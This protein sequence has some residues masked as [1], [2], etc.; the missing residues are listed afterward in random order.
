MALFVYITEECKK[1]AAKHGRWNDV[2][3]LKDKIISDQRTN[4]LDRYPPPYLK[5]RF[6]RQERLIAAER[7]VADHTVVCFYRLLIRGNDTY[8][9]FKNNPVVF[10]DT[11]F[12][13]L[14]QEVKLEEWLET[15]LNQLDSG[16]K[17]PA[18]EIEQTY[19]WNVMTEGSAFGGDFHIY[20]SEDWVKAINT[21]RLRS[22]LFPIANK[23]MDTV[24]PDVKEEFQWLDISEAGNLKVLFRNFK[25]C[26]KVFLAGIC[27]NQDE[28]EQERL[29]QRYGSILKEAQVDGN[30]IIRFSNRSY[31]ALILADTDN[32]EAIEKNADSNLALS[33]EE[34]SLLAS[35]HSLD[36][37]ERQTGF[38]LF[39]NGRAGSGK[40]TIL[41]YLFTHYVIN[42]L[43]HIG[44]TSPPLYLT[45]SEDL[46]RR[47]KE[48][49]E[50]LVTS[51]Y[52]HTM[53]DLPRERLPEVLDSCFQEFKSFLINLIPDEERNILFSAEKYVNYPRF[54]REWEQKFSKDPKAAKAYGPDISW[55][56]IRTY[57][58]G[59]SPDDYMDPDEY[60]ELPREEYSVS[61]STFKKVYT[62]VWEGWYQHKCRPD[63]EE[64]IYWDDQDLV[65]YVLDNDLIL[66]IYPAVFCDEAQDFTKI[67]LEAILRLSLF[68][69]RK[70]D[71]QEL[72]RIPFAFAGDPLQTL[73][74]TGFRW[75]AIKSVFVQKFIHSLDPQQIFGQRELNYRELSYNYRS[76]NKVVKLNNSIQ[77]FRA[78]LFDIKNLQPQSTWQ[79]EENSPTPVFFNKSIPEVKERLKEQ[80]DLTIIVPCGEGGEKGFVKNDPYL[81]QV[82]E[83]DEEGVPQNV[84]SP[85]RSKGLEFK[86]VA[87][88]GFGEYMPEGFIKLIEAI[89][90]D[91]V[92]EVGD[93]LL[94]YGYFVNQLYVAASRPQKRL[95]VVDT[96]EGIR[97][98]WKFAVD[99]D[100]QQAI[101][102]KIRNGEEIWKDKLG[103][104]H[105]G[106]S[107]SWSQDREDPIKRAKQLEEEGKYSRDQFLLRQAAM[108]YKNHNEI[109]KS[110]LCRALAFEFNQQYK[111]AGN[112]Y[113]DGESVENALQ[114]F[115][116]GAEYAEIEAIAYKEAISNTLEARISVYLSESTKSLGECRRVLDELLNRIER[117]SSLAIRIG[118]MESWRRAIRKIL[119]SLL[120]S[121]L[122]ESENMKTIINQ[123]KALEENNIPLDQERMG[124]LYLKAGDFQQGLSILDQSG[125]MTSHEYKAAKI[126]LLIDRYRN[127][128]EHSFEKEENQ[129][130][131][132][133]FLEKDEF[134]D[135]ITVFR[136]INSYN[137]VARVINK[138]VQTKKNSPALLSSFANTFLQLLLAN[139]EWKNAVTFIKTQKHLSLDSKAS[140]KLRRLDITT[141]LTWTIELLKTASISPLLP[142]APTT[143]KSALSD[144]LRELFFKEDIKSEA[145]FALLPSIVVGAAFE[146][147][148]RDI[149]TLEF[150]KRAQR[151]N[152]LGKA[153]KVRLKE[154]WIKSK[155]KQAIRERDA[156]KLRQ[157]EKHFSDAEREAEKRGLVVSDLSEFPNAN[158]LQTIMKTA[159]DA[160][161]SPLIANLPESEVTGASLQKNN[162]I[163]PR[164]VRSG[165]LPDRITLNICGFEIKVSRKLKR[166]NIEKEA[167]METLS[168][169][170]NN[171]VQIIHADV[172]YEDSQKQV[173]I[174]G[175][176]L[177]LEKI[178]EESLKLELEA[179]GLAFSIQ[180]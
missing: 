178:I 97:G 103:A 165:N 75:E 9:S 3:K 115:W 164:E 148:G 100:F 98:L 109:R 29:L 108:I 24:A 7:S 40:S 49:V 55:H 171:G 179:D 136:K 155:H 86:R 80:V 88:Y 87:L 130:I 68:S 107:E 139:G 53:R 133:F 177:K 69:D 83:V 143:Q 10:G 52:Q 48:V 17:E 11:H 160:P 6:A 39:I 59:I 144:Y 30:D 18:D 79:Y 99:P 118:A 1:D 33:P 175:W 37:A 122:S 158:E 81:R 124:R 137:G 152:S 157:A 121:D 169:V 176:H 163:H 42:Y 174:K 78:A 132:Q 101:L 46:V 43:E 15:Q 16:V 35:A 110:H 8:N 61:R 116:K 64:R 82:I 90:T 162:G 51:N 25:S 23:L 72:G 154:R 128:P 112:S 27:D 146:R 4:R 111:E 94:T 114:S 85:A 74:P 149:D 131:A 57:I 102:S 38:P 66:P 104:L 126:N 123:F 135:A 89:T 76:T 2:L 84:L 13:P 58:K 170:V 26:Q 95:F 172:P 142:I 44:K 32:W 91:E 28:E 54:K 36:E 63:D 173:Y 21:E 120:A 65:R 150:Y 50:S 156:G 19:L 166:V 117:D 96:E 20:E 45:Y 62:K 60:E 71:S 127:N 167:S 113:L 93:Q 145:L 56:V 153:E 161:I 147:A 141:D 168:L 129:L 22:R 92:P 134:E 140:I 159:R 73:N 5:K 12:A 70:L 105:R 77:A 31:P 41:Q 138:L 67:E 119:D 14:V 106:S 47:S 34:S 180:L 151:L 125:H